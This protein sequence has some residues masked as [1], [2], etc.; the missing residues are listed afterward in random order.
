MKRAVILIF[1][2]LALV[3]CSRDAK[4]DGVLSFRAAPA[5]DSR[6]TAGTKSLLDEHTI[7]TRISCMSLGLYSNGTLVASRHFESTKGRIKLENAEDFTAYALVNMGNMCGEFPVSE[8]GIEDICYRL[9]SYDQGAGS[10]NTLGI[11][12]AGKAYF[13]SSPSEEE[14]M[15]P[16]KRLLAKIIVNVR[17]DWPG[18]KISK[19]TA[20]NMNGTLKPF[21]K[22]VATCMEDV[23]SESVESETLNSPAQSASFV[24]YVPENMQGEIPG[25]NESHEKSPD[26][27]PEVEMRKD[28]LT[29]IQ[30]DAVGDGLYNGRMTYRTYLGN[31]AIGNFDI[32]RDRAYIWNITY[33]EDK[34]SNNEW[35]TDS[36][37][38]ED[39][40]TLS[41][42]SPV[43]VF[44]GMEVRL[45]DYTTT[46]IPLNTV[47]WNVDINLSS[48]KPN[49]VASIINP[50]NLS[51]CR[52]KMNTW[53]S[54]EE[55]QNFTA[56]VFPLHNPS[57]RLTGEIKIYPATQSIR[58]QNTRNGNYYLYP[59]RKT[60]TSPDYTVTY[61][62]EDEN[63]SV[64]A[65]VMGNGGSQWHWTDSPAEG[66]SSLYLGDI[67]KEYETI[68]YSA[69]PVTIPGD[70]SIAATTTYG[71]EDQANIHVC[72]TRFIKWTDRSTKVPSASSNFS[73]Y[74]YMSEN[75]IFI[76]FPAGSSYTTT[77]G[78]LFTM[79]DTPLSF[80]AGDR[81]IDI[82]SLNQM[83]SGF[84]FEGKSLCN[85]NWSDRIGITYSYGLETSGIYGDAA[86]SGYLHLVPKPKL[87]LSNGG[88]YTIKVFAQN[89]Y[90]D[91]TRHTIE[92]RIMNG[93]NGTYYELVLLP[94][95]TKIS[96]G[97]ELALKPVLYEIKLSGSGSLARYNMQELDVN[98]SFLEWNGAPGGVFQAVNP[99]NYRVSCVYRGGLSTGYADIEVSLSDIDI[100]G[101]WENET[102]VILD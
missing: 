33:S 64:T 38:L 79:Y 46:N 4:G 24:L 60:D 61:Y 50:N 59:G 31:S 49:P 62:D 78:I 80:V 67:G 17:T 84:A 82:K 42:V 58:W 11:P 25:I 86:T 12:M 81:S 3:S 89:G 47:G 35:K 9:Q 28:F 36:S 19:I 6:E 101:N 23:Y 18:G 52:F 39:L 14:I 88:R 5:M 1:T 7:D 22:S 100:S 55:M 65:S 66:I 99:G 48:G 94:A 16:V 72:D 73:S 57:G 53:T 56:K 92:A 29:Y 69:L 41:V 15:I 93:G 21:G 37:F 98:D 85:D 102:P 32:E 76:T 40:R 30:V 95:I 45:Q 2:F 74:K 90:N 87:T 71:N 44:P 26:I 83:L 51:G 97:A 96:V 27:I 8:S 68:R 10:V 63:A 13:I 91:A 75:K 34:L 20:C 77:G 70:Y 54:P 43:F